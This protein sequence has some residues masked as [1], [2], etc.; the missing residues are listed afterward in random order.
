MNKTDE[1]LLLTSDITLINMKTL[2]ILTERTDT[3]LSC[4]DLTIHSD[5]FAT[6]DE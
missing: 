3:R 6:S 5:R 4:G 2:C 1:Y